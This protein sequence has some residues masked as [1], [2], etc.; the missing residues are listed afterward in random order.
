LL[1]LPT[2]IL[3]QI[4]EHVDGNDLITMRLVCNSLHHA[5]N[6]PFGIFYLSHRHHVLT[7]K[8]I[9][10]LLEIV[11]HHSFGLYVK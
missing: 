4:S 10:S 11:T 6:K 2:E 1:A 8:S 9:E 3:C 5:A 7:R